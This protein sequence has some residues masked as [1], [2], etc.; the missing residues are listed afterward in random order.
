MFFILAWINFNLKLVI[1]KEEASLVSQSYQNRYKES[2]P[3]VP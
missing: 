2:E 1:Q 3:A